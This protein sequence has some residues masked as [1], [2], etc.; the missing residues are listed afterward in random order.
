MPWFSKLPVPVFR[1]DFVRVPYL[2]H[3][4]LHSHPILLCFIALTKFD[5]EYKL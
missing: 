1:T 3:A 4:M 2:L 5:E